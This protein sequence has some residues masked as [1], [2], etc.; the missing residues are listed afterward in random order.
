MVWIFLFAVMIWLILF[1]RKRFSFKYDVSPMVAETKPIKG[2]KRLTDHLEQS[3]SKSYMETLK[4][5]L[6]KKLS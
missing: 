1:L 3:L 4:S 6:K 2:L 5:G